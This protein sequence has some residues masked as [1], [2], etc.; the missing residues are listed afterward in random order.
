MKLANYMLVHE[1]KNIPL[2]VGKNILQRRQIGINR[3]YVSRN[4]CII[5]VKEKKGKTLIILEDN[6]LNG[7]FVSA[8]FIKKKAIILSENDKL[9]FGCML[10]YFTLTKIATVVI[11]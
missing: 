10:D 3:Q 7:T 9:G 6:S 8:S 11:D 5:Y 4:H 2:R 1:R